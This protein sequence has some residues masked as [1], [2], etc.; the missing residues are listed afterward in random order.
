MDEPLRFSSTLNPAS[1]TSY[2]ATLLATH[3]PDGLS[4]AADLRPV[5]ETA[6]ARLEDNFSRIHRKYFT[7]D[8]AARFDH[9]NGDHLAMFLYLLANSCWTST[10]DARIPT[11]LFSL[12]K[13]LHGLDLFYSV[14][15][16]ATF[17]LVHPVGTVIG[18][19]EY[20]DY[21]V[22]YQ[23]CTIGSE[24]GRYPRFGEGVVLNSRVSVIGDVTVGDN[25]VFGA[26]AFL[27]GG[28][29]PSDSIVV[30]QFPTHRILPAGRS[31]RDRF[32]DAAP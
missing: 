8:G 15:L 12:N 1:L 29:V 4:S 20:G 19:A 25:V 13:I 9:L 3:F 17:L 7:V 6:L 27:L 18:N 32:F 30:G 2:I 10:G 28:D 22:V 26:N 11:K 14:E 5:V 24:S 31:V 16:P 21:L 23:N